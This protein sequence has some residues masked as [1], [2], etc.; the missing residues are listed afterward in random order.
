VE[1]KLVMISGY[2]SGE[3]GQ[4]HSEEINP[5]LLLELSEREVRVISSFTEQFT[6][7]GLQFSAVSDTCIRVLSVPTCFK[8]RDERQ[9]NKTAKFEHL[10]Q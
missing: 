10:M 9:V 2:Q 7:L 4:F 3:K 6:R 1:V 8:L 5:P